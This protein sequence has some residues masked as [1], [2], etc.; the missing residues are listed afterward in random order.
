MAV[1]IA[2]GGLNPE[3][4]T[5]A[6]GTGYCEPHFLAHRS[7][8][9]SAQRMRLPASGFQQFLR[10]DAARPLQQFEDRR[11]LTA[12]AGAG[13]FLS[14]FGRFLGWGGLLPPLPLPGATFARRAPAVAF[15]VAF[16]SGAVSV[17][18]VVE[19]MFSP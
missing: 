6:K 17:C 7:R 10:S 1:G 4:E 19:I 13:G 18:S 3:L 12:V 14:A 16:V 8:K 11:R 15:F 2:F 9:E 5:V